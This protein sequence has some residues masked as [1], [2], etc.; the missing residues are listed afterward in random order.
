MKSTQAHVLEVLKLM[1]IADVADLQFSSEVTKLL[2]AAA[3]AH[4]SSP[5]Y[6]SALRPYGTTNDRVTPSQPVPQRLTAIVPPPTKKIAVK[7]KSPKK[8]QYV[9]GNKRTITAAEQEQLVKGWARANLSTGMIVQMNGTRDGH[10]IRQVVDTHKKDAIIARQYVEITL[11][12]EIAAAQRA[13]SRK[14]TTVIAVSN[15]GNTK[16]YQQT[17]M[18]TSHQLGKLQSIVTYPSVNSNV[19]IIKKLP[20][21]S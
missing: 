21:V 9:T 3:Q 12:S 11:A 20:F 4:R 17:S 2:Q 14:G 19:M 18:F 7:P 5:Q 6:K 16:Y 8:I 1:S 13:L 15:L 10:G